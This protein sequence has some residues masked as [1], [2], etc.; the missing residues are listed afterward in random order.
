MGS[1]SLNSHDVVKKAEF[2]VRRKDSS[3]GPYSPSNRKE[4]LNL[5]EPWFI[6]IK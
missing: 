2:S 4:S 3:D 1:L 6:Y 5:S